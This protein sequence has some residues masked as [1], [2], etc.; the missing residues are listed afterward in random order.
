MPVPS[1]DLELRDATLDDAALVADLDSLRDPEAPFDP[2]LVRHWW[3]TSDAIS[4]TM[5]QIAEHEGAAVA[6]VSA[7]HDPWSPESRRFGTIRPGLRDDFWTEVRYQALTNIAEEWLRSEDAQ[8][9]ILR[10]RDDRAR[11]LEVLGRL[12]YR[13][14]RRSRL[15]ELDLVARREQLLGTAERCR[16]EMRAQGVTLSAL[17]DDPDPEVLQKLYRLTEEAE[18]DI[19]TT[20]PTTVLSFDDWDHLWFDNPCVRK[21]RFWI[22]REGDEIVGVSVLD[23]PIT[24]GVPVTNF[25]GTARRVRGRGIARALKYETIAQAIDLGFMRVRTYNDGANAPILHVNQ[26]M[27]YAAIHTLIELHRDL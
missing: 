19:P 7:A 11:D 24:R 13:E 25:T 17:A 26:Q 14:T 15:S 10:L 27:G 3:K 21:D 22:A 1:I 6:F 16:G 9:A 20:V 2:L 8:T 12:G 4:A 23:F 5:R 18:Q